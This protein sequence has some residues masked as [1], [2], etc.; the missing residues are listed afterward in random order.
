[1]PGGHC[2]VVSSSHKHDWDVKW[3]ERERFEVES[4]HCRLSRGQIEWHSPESMLDGRHTSMPWS[5]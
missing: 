1:M 4:R 5:D 3:E 2:K